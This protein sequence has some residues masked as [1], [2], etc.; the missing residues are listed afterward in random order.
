[1]K[2]YNYLFFSIALFVFITDQATK[3]WALYWLSGGH[4]IKILPFLNFTLVLNEGIAFG[5]FH[6]GGNLKNYF[7]IFITAIATIILLITHFKIKKP[8]GLKTI[9]LALVF[10]G[11]VGNLYDRIFRGYVVDF[12]DLYFKTFHW[13]VFNLADTYISL[14]LIIIFYLQIIKKEHIF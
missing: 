13:P 7:L 12:I 8:T 14:G 3:I 11:A 10:G 2:R 4:S 9:L 1:M 5:L 6:E